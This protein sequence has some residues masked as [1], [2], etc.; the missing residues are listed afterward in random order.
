MSRRAKTASLL[1][2]AASILVAAVRADDRPGG[3][4]SATGAITGRVVDLNGRPIAGAEVWGLA[5]R[6]KVG[7]TRADADGRFRLAPL[8]EDKP[9]TVWAD[10]PGFARQRRE[11]VHVFGGR[12]H[13]I[14]PLVLL[15]GTRICGRVVD[16]RRRPIA[17]VTIMVDDY[18][19]V[20]GH[21]ISSDQT[22]WTLAGDAEGRFTT[23]P[24]PAGEVHFLFAAPGKVRTWLER[25]A[26]PGTTEADLG[27]ITLADEVPIRGV[28]VDQDGTPAPGVEVMADY[29]YEGAAKTGK[30][31]RFTIHGAGKGA[32]Q[33][34]LES[35]DYLAPKP[36][37]LGLDRTDLKL[38]VI[39]AY[40]I[41]GTAVDNETGKPVLI[42]TVRLCR[43]VRDPDGSYT[44]YG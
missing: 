28:V 27:D 11:G 43:V 35:N 44:L 40:E 29:D 24:V 7:S 39:K 23:P 4:P 17:G 15:P 14:S 12:D 2:A 16:A 6:D 21:T 25:I 1:A 37:D 31:G 19:F 26:E 33:L 42:D 10:A 32:K 18:R 34:R 22:E 41:H 38:T 3:A 30:D 20:L 5:F 13:D 9:I 36:F 8:K